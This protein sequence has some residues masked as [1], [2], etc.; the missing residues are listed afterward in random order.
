MGKKVIEIQDLKRHYQMGQTVV[1]ALDG[2][3]FDVEENEYI[4][5][6]GPSG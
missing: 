2:V 4:A 5:I 3:T 1:R 6:M